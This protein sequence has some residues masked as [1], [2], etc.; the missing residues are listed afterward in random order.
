MYTGDGT[1]YIKV[2]IPSIHG[3]YSMKEYNGQPV[4]NYTRDENLP[5]Y[6]SLLLPHLP[7]E[8]DVVAITSLDSGNNQFIVIGLTGGNYSSNMTNV[9]GV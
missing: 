2:R 1:L 9:G 8:G 6:P 7:N 3:P 5:Y 4:R